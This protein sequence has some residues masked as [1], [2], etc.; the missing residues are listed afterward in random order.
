MKVK[1]YFEAKTD[2][3]QEY[4]VAFDIGESEIPI[5]YS[6]LIAGIDKDKVLEFTG[7][8]G[9]VKS[10]NFNVITPEEYKERFEDD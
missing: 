1:I 9:M 10:E 4:G 3:G 7:F 6:K 5:D 2:D 8:S